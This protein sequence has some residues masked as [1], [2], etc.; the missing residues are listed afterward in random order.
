MLKILLC[1]SR[2]RKLVYV[3]EPGLVSDGFVHL[4]D[5]FE[6]KKMVLILND[7]TKFIMATFLQK[8]QVLGSRLLNSI[9][10][11][12]RHPALGSLLAETEKG[13]HGQVVLIIPTWAAG[14]T[15]I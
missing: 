9:F 8:Q 1:S 7:W 3:G 12:W 5:R 6:R 2:G 14:H 10:Q 4:A 15:L 11:M 13:G